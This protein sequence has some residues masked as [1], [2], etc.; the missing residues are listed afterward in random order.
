MEKDWF[1]DL[2]LTIDNDKQLLDSALDAYVKFLRVGSATGLRR[3]LDRAGY[4][5]GKSVKVPLYAELAHHYL[6]KLLVDHP[7]MVDLRMFY[8]ASSSSKNYHIVRKVLAATAHVVNYPTKVLDHYKVFPDTQEPSTKQE[9]SQP[10]PNLECIQQGEI[11]MGS[12]PT[13]TGVLEAIPQA[14]FT[15]DSSKAFDK[16][17]GSTVYGIDTQKLTESQAIE[18]INKVNLEIDN[19]ESVQVESKRITNM[20]ADLKKQKAAIVKLLDSGKLSS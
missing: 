20:V 5:K 10:K 13:T 14:T 6:V 16:V 12:D 4:P 19:L 1:S 7:D 15:T 11:I 8:Y 3:L 17:T 18:A 9:P 2:T